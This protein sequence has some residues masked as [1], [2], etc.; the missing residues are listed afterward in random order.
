MNDRKELLAR[1]ELL[2]H[3]N[4]AFGDNLLE[5]IRERDEAQAV[6]ERLVRRLEIMCREWR[7]VFGGPDENRTP[8]D[9]LENAELLI[10]EFHARA[11]RQ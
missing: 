1:I 8:G 3:E 4:K 10:A 6:A 7:E 11:T 9:V 5:A 2:E